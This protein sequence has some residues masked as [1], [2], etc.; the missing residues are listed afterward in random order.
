VHRLT[1]QELVAVAARGALLLDTRTELHRR[2]QREFPGALV[3]DR[4]VLEWRLDP[5]SPGRIPEA[6]GPDPEVVVVCRQGCSSRLAG[7]E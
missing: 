2:A 4:T 3:I 5:T 6:T 7:R 1:P